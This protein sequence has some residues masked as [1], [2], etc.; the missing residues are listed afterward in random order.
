M[1]KEGNE[2]QNVSVSPLFRL[3][4]ASVTPQEEFPVNGMSS[5][6]LVVFFWLK[7]EDAGFQA[8]VLQWP[9]LRLGDFPWKQNPA[10]G[11][12]FPRMAVLTYKC[13]LRGLPG[14]H[15]CLPRR[16]GWVPATGPDR[17]GS[18]GDLMSGHSHTHGGL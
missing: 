7:P 16:K 11:L 10:A 14:S 12:S 4:W 1:R 18:P 3:F 9:V 2:G 5:P 8:A 13:P 17:S 15:V 6:S